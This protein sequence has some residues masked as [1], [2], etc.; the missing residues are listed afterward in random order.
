MPGCGIT[1][2]FFHYPI[3]IDELARGTAVQGGVEGED[4]LK[5]YFVFLLWRSEKVLECRVVV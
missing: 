1:A 2:A 4:I 3:N 5:I